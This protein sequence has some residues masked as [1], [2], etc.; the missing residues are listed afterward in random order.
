MKILLAVDGSSTTKRMLA[1]LAAHDE[2]LGRDNQYTA[3]TIVPLIPPHAAALLP[4][5]SID[6]WYEEEAEKVL[7]PVRAFAKQNGW[8]LDDRFV[9]GHAG[10]QIVALA[11]EGG[12]DMI[13][14][15]THGHSALGNVVM[16]STATRV[17]ARTRKPVLL[18]P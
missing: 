3:L 14:M 9:A 15:G 18:I 8:A 17:L 10:D 4:R 2:M 1:T 7:S 13:V 12:F 16:G 6:G 5:S 11:D